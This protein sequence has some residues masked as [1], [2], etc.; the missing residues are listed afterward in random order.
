MCIPGINV[1]D[2]CWKNQLNRLTSVYTQNTNIDELSNKDKKKAQSAYRY[3]NRDTEGKK[4][5]PDYID[6]KKLNSFQITQ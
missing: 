6:T 1:I 2:A 4:H 3:L 5:I